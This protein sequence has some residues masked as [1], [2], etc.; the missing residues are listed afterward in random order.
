MLYLFNL[1][2]GGQLRLEQQRALGLVPEGT[3]PE[4]AAR[5]SHGRGMPGGLAFSRF[6]GVLVGFRAPMPKREA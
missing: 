6:F 5:Q 1:I 4:I 3:A 2:T